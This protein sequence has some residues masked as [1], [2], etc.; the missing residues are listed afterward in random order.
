MKP[1]KFIELFWKL[2]ESKHTGKIVVAL[3]EGGIR[4]VQVGC[5]VFEDKISPFMDDG[6]MVF[7]DKYGEIVGKIINLK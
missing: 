2:V 4:D 7:I 1:S 5:K 3:N 6:N